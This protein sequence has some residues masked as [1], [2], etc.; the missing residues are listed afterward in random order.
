MKR[1]T[2]CKYEPLGGCMNTSAILVIKGMK[3]GKE[4]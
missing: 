3:N 4:N 1:K 2:V